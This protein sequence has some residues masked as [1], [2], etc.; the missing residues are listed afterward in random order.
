M[1]LVCLHKLTA[2]RQVVVDHVEHM[3]LDA[4]EQAC[5]NDRVGAVA[6]VRERNPVPAAQMKEDAERSDSDSTR[7]VGFARSIHRTWAQ[8]DVREATLGR[9]LGD[10]LILLQLGESIRLCAGDVIAFN[11]ARL[12]DDSAAAKV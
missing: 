9:V 1:L 10:E 3:A 12:V 5:A 8:S 4:F 6:D 2:G 11:G 7:D